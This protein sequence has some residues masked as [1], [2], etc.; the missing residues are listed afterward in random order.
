MELVA[1]MQSYLSQTVLPLAA[2]QLDGVRLYGVVN[3]AAQAALFL[4]LPLGGSLP[5]R[6]GIA[7]LMLVLTLVAVLGALLGRCLTESEPEDGISANHMAASVV[8]AEG[9]G[10]AL[11]TIRR[12]H[13][14]RHRL[15]PVDHPDHRAQILWAVVLGLTPLMVV[16]LARATRGEVVD[17]A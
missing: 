14:A 15:R 7:P 17:E 2:A 8:M 9:V 1:G 3:V 10:T 13:L 11:V 5:A 16:Q 6:F 12:L 4:T